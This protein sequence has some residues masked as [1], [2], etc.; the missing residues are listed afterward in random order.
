MQQNV[1]NKT[2]KQLL[3][4]RLD[5]LDKILLRQGR[6]NRQAARYRACLAYGPN[7]PLGFL[8]ERR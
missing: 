1:E 2:A 3:E 4:E 7:A 6:L 5:R 8:Y